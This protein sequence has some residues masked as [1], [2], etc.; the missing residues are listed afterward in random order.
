MGLISGLLTL[1]LAPVRG[2]IWLV[3]DSCEG[4]L[5]RV[6]QG[7]ISVRDNVKRKTIL[8]RAGKS[9]LVP[10][11]EIPAFE[12]LLNRYDHYVVD[13]QVY[14][15]PISNF[16]ANTHRKWVVDNDAFATNQFLHPYQ[17]AFYQGL[18]RSAG[19]RTV[20]GYPAAQWIRLRVSWSATGVPWWRSR[21]KVV[22]TSRPWPTG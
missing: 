11:Y 8:L 13:A 14:Q 1:P 20:R 16:K 5:T 12:F 7:V 9:Y 22:T 17:G 10:A 21:S 2:T 3:Q 18:A 6:R 4:T 19:R 15:S